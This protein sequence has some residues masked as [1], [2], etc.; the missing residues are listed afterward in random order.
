MRNCY[1]IG[2]LDQVMDFSESAVQLVYA[3][4]GV[5]KTSFL[6]VLDDHGKGA[7]PVDRVYRSREAS[8]SILLEDG[9]SLPPE[10][11]LAVGSPTDR[12][13]KDATSRLMVNEELR[14]EYE[15]LAKS[16]EATADSICSDMARASGVG[17]DSRGYL[18]RAFAVGVA[19]VPELLR[20]LG[21]EVRTREN[22]RLSFVP[23]KVVF[24]DRARAFMKDPDVAALLEDYMDTYNTLIE[25]SE[26]FRPGGFNHYHADA[27]AKSLAGAKFFDADH[28]VRLSGIDPA[29][30][31]VHSAQ[32]LRDLVTKEKDRIL[33]DSGLTKRFEAIDKKLD[34]HQ[35]LRDLRDFLQAHPDCVPL[36][37]DYEA[38]ERDVWLSYL[39]EID[40]LVTFVDRYEQAVGRMA[41]I[42]ESAREQQTDWHAVVAEF[43]SR[44]DLPY[45]L[46]VENQQDVILRDQ[47]P[48]LV[49]DYN[50]GRG[51]TA[52]LTDAE[53]GNVL[54][55]GEKRAL[56]ILN[57]IFEIR[58][59]GKTG[60]PTLVIFDDPADS[61]DY[62]NKYGIV[63]YLSDLAQS[64]AFMMIILTHNFDFYRT[65]FNR[66]GLRHQNAF[67]VGREGGKVVFYDADYIRQ[68]LA[69]L[70]T[71][72]HMDRRCLIAAIPFARNM[73]EYRGGTNSDQ[74]ET[75]TSALHIKHGTDGL[76]LREVVAI[77]DE[78]LCPPNAVPCNG[79]RML[80]IILAEA[81]SCV[82][83]GE[84]TC[85]EKK[86]CVSIAIR[87][88]AEQYMLAR[89]GVA[90]EE[91][92][93]VNQT[94][95]I[96]NR[97]REVASS[98]PAMPVLKRV[99]LMTPESIHL[100]SFMY[101]PLL[102]MSESQLCEL[103][104]ALAQLLSC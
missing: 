34:A 82:A 97:F 89:P 6:Q 13:A 91:E 63:E 15:S 21:D 87:L 67:M 88:R 103:N 40:E 62:R 8:Y 72:L 17:R 32:E 7:R 74:Y 94:R 53:L 73:I 30:V 48:V 41:E 33:T 11:V 77:L 22:P 100:N 58:A 102:D 71:R 36:L 38:F 42:A 31:D 43:E 35:D 1:G 29:G 54:S 12:M 9:R 5:M 86:V 52:Q 66:L 78:V 44:F 26:F 79:E 50:D 75:L 28:V 37:A 99:M 65:V 80:D 49:F 64:E 19:E 85:L 56:Y 45:R 4:N 61:F 68:P 60:M 27:V 39:F 10:W 59:R 24:G 90:F 69:K 101:E 46:R 84:P 83:G 70:R 18:S 55:T 3:P 96:F 95:A 93:S 23:P 47:T 81:D 2:E 51:E 20:R 98:D 25:R 57:V 104:L 92:P 14:S 76:S 16:V